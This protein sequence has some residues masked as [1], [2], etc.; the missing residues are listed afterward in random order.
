MGERIGTDDA[1]VL[2]MFDELS[3]VIDC[4]S[5]YCKFYVYVEGF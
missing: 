1:V 2:L 5:A 3:D 4:T